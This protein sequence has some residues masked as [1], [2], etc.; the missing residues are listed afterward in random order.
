MTCDLLPWQQRSGDRYIETN[1]RDHKLFF[2]Y[3]SASA[4]LNHIQAYSCLAEELALVAGLTLVAEL[5][6][7]TNCRLNH[8]QVF[9]V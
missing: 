6:L 3:L 4:T 5:T 8:M 2:A 9:L 1:A 7:V